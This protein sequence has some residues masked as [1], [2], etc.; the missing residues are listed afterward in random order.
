M[1]LMPAARAAA[2]S[3]THGAMAAAS[4]VASPPRGALGLQNPFCISTT[5]SAA[6][7][8]ESSM[9]P[10]HLII[11]IDAFGG[12]R[13]LLFV[14]AHVSEFRQIGRSHDVLERLALI[15]LCL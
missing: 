15:E 4:R 5:I 2:T 7:R 6:L 8:F 9:S 11:M 3:L 10:P 12:A 13:D 1:T 14:T